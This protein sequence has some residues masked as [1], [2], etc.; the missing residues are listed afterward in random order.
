MT[1]KYKTAVT[2]TVTLSRVIT[3][4]GGTVRVTIRKSTLIIRVTIGGTEKTPGPLA[5]CK[6]PRMKITPRSY[7]YTTRMPERTKSA[8][9]T[10]MTPIT[11]KT[12]GSMKSLLHK[13]IQE[14]E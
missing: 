2:L 9:T 8:R 1:L 4:C 3:S 11:V 14:K 13:L 6:R 7:C 12:I 5:P 10:I